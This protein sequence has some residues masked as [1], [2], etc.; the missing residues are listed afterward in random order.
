MKALVEGFGGG[1]KSK[2]EGEAGLTI[3]S[4]AQEAMQ[5]SALAGITSKAD[6]RWLP[7]TR[8]EDRGL[9]KTSPV[10]DLSRLREKNLEVLRKR[11]KKGQGGV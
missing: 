9:P 4:E 1:I 5:R 6:P 2:A 11:V 8:G 7:V 3:P 10:F